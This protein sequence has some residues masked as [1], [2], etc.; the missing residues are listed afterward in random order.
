MGAVILGAAAAC[1]LV[2]YLGRGATVTQRLAT[3]CD[4]PALQAGGRLV[5]WKDG[6]RAAKDLLPVGSGL[7]TYRYAYRAYQQRPYDLWYYHAENQYLEALVE[8]GLPGLCLLLTMIGLVA[9]A[10]WRLLKRAP[11]A[12]TY[13]LGLAGTFALSSQAIHAA[14]DFGLYLP[15]NMLLLAL[16]CGAV[17]GRAARIE[18]RG[19]A[20]SHW[21][22]RWRSRLVVLPPLPPLAAS[23]CLGLT[24]A[25]LFGCAEARRA[26]AVE[27]ALACA[28][29]V[30][31]R[32]PN[33]IE[34]L[35]RCLARFAFVPPTRLDDV[36][37]HLRLAQ[38]WTNRMRVGLVQALRQDAAAGT[39]ES[40]LWSA[41]D[42][43][44]L[45]GLLQQLLAQQRTAE[46]A[47]VRQSPPILEN[48]PHALTHLRLARGLC[49]LLPDV[50]LLLAQLTVLEPSYADN[51]EDLQ[52]V[53]LTAR[54][55]PGILTRCGL[56]ELQA[57]RISSACETWRMSLELSE[58]QLPEI[59]TAARPRI[60]L[61]V[62][63]GE[64]APD[65]PEL[66]IEIASSQFTTDEDRQVRRALLAEADALLSGSRR[67][68][69][70][71]LWLRGRLGLLRNDFRGAALYFTQALAIRPEETAWR[72]ELAVALKQS[73][74]YQEAQEQA[75]VC[76]RTEPN[77]EQY[78]ALLREVIR[79]QLTPKR[80][81]DADI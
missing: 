30:D 2:A 27:S 43:T 35:D 50:H 73:G 49:P 12:A 32:R 61:A 74:R 56:L 37:S 17:C 79:A 45:H 24:G 75:R 10:C 23:C 72:Y 69:A 19:R 8:A 1:L 67:K 58:K 33:S 52:R 42:T 41:T 39:S 80:R 68:G 40:A 3:I 63:I 62:H 28:K 70:R 44:H 77:N 59:L 60:D 78:E 5:N 64:L 36:E 54:G 81:T 29:R 51:Q 21:A 76:A 46:A 22:A 20:S 16:V 15:A 11:D 6:W 48:L 14:F 53:R 47:A 7:G 55:N 38:L 9:L 26:A 4:E 25:L 66:L 18:S 31:I 34:S 57:G 65:S 71:G 13:A